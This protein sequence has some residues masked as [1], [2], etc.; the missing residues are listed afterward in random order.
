MSE[1][2]LK[3]WNIKPFKFSGAKPGTQWQVLKN[4]RKK[5][6]THPMFHGDIFIWSIFY[7]HKFKKY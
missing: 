2:N 4:L 5:V 6:G 1:L 7:S 3:K